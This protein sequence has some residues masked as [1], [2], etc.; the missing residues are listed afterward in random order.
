MVFIV[1]MVSN[2]VRRKSRG[3]ITNVST[4]TE[5]TDVEINGLGRGVSL[6]CLH[7][8]ARRFSLVNHL[9]RSVALSGSL[10]IYRYSGQGDGQRRSGWSRWRG[11]GRRGRRRREAFRDARHLRDTAECRRDASVAADSTT[12]QALRFSRGGYAGRTGL[13]VHAAQ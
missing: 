2:V 3:E 11:R 8:E 5:T 9:V 4:S 6:A 13:S 10:L 1:S 12:D 7:N